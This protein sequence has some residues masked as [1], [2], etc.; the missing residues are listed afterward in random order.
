MSTRRLAP[1]I[2]ELVDAPLAPEE[3]LARIRA[4]LTPEEIADTAALVRWFTRR[5]PTVRDRMAY[6][7]RAYAQWTRTPERIP[8]DDD[9]RE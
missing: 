4:P 3:F 6:I 5:Y 2:A 1:E 7:R 8:R 9:P